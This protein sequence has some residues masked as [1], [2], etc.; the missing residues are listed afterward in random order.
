MKK[1]IFAIALTMVL[2]VTQIAAAQSGDKPADAKPTDAQ[3]TD[4]QMGNDNDTA[5][6][7]DAAQ[8]SVW[9]GT[10]KSLSGE[11]V[12]L[13]KYKDHVVLVVNVASKCG[14]TKQYAGLEKLYQAHKDNGLVVV[15]FPCNQF[16]KQEPGSSAEIAEFCSSKF[17]VTFDM[18]EK[19][20]VNG[21]DR[22]PLYVKLCEMDLEP[23]GAGDVKWNFEKFVVGKDGM[24][25]ARFSSRVSPNDKELLALLKA[26][27]EK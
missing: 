7:N 11:D 26:E 4:D 24:P 10:F 5:S 15:G 22:N 19:S 13:S 12:D 6:E 25:V 27:L 8:N 17:N 3:I 1:M 16:G 18:F 21:D 2:A 14:F 23:K 20:D 9:Q